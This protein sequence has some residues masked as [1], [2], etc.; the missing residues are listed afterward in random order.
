[1]ARLDAA[2]AAVRA[3]AGRAVQEA[4]PGA[5]LVVGFSG[6]TDSLALLLGAS[7]TA[8][9]CGRRVVAVHVD[10]GLS[11]DAA[12]MALAAAALA[13]TVGVP[14]ESVAVRVNENL[15]GGPEAA[16]RS[17]RYAALDAARKRHV[18]SL[19]LLGHTADDQAESVL[20]GLARGSGARSLSGIPP[21]RAQYR[22][23]LLGLTRAQTAQAC[24][25]M[26]LTPV[27]DPSNDDLTLLR[28]RVRTIVLP[29]LEKELGPGAA[30]GL[31]RS[32]ELLRA[33]ADL[34][35]DLAG[36]AWDRCARPQ[37]AGTVLDVAA[38]TREPPALRS[39]V[40]RR[41]AVACGAP[42]GA[43]GA[44]HVHALDAL[45]VDWHGQTAVA[46][47]GGL[48]ACRRSGMLVVEPAQ[49]PA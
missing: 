29:V 37:T 3:A 16:A 25:A 32:A 7:W 21:A 47:P 28:N 10:H 6:G 38:L 4:P 49:R 40:I 46:L 39:R 27:E 36:S 9:R 33:D 15:R 13:E 22:R 34:L 23:P 1:M 35:D 18:A 48:A 11:P 17:A 8:A 20:L 26:R 12:Q 30:P 2:V 41:W 43:V 44:V 5:M 19:V 31:V 45:V 24:R 14:F 42:D